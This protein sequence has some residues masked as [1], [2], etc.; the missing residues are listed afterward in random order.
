MKKGHLK[1]R[2][3]LHEV[4][5]CFFVFFFAKSLKYLKKTKTNAGL[6]IIRY[7]LTGKKS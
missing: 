7:D 1:G 3:R 2:N 5:E 4:Y 6:I